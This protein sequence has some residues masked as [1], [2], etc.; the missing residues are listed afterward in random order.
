YILADRTERFEEARELLLKALALN[1]TDAAILDS[2]GWLHYRTGNYPEALGYLRRAFQAY[3]DA[4]IAAHL[5][6]V[7]WIINERDEAL[8]IW[9]E[10]LKL[11]PDSELIKNSMERL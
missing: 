6:E 10:G 1:P 5:G 3:P 9:N 2:V 11:S 7:L 4:E 8:E